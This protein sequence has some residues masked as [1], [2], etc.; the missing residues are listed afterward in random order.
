MGLNSDMA[1][2][3]PLSSS[4]HKNPVFNLL[5]AIPE[6]SS[7]LPGSMLFDTGVFSNN[8]FSAE[9]VIFF[10]HATK[11]SIKK[12]EIKVF[13]KTKLIYEVRKI[14]IFSLSDKAT[15]LQYQVH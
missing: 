2:G 3:F 8:V 5:S 7:T 13:F 1:G 10:V 4:T 11:M 12:N 14:I 6:A 15:A 9:E